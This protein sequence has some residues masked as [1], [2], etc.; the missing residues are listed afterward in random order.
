MLTNYKSM[1]INML[2]SI[3]NMKLRN[4]KE[5]LQDF[6]LTYQIDKEALIKRLEEH[7]LYYDQA[8]NQF[9]RVSA[10]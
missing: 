7:H 10:H 3:V 4:E 1:D 9:T 6:C 2:L 8:H 5:S